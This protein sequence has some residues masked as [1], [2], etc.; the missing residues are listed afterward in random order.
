MFRSASITLIAAVLIVLNLV[1]PTALLPALVRLA[2]GQSAAA[3]EVTSRFIASPASVAA[4]L[5]MAG[6]EMATIQE[7]DED[8]KAP[9]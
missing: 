4:A 2:T 7:L 6:D 8:C 5:A 9:A 3:S 1:I